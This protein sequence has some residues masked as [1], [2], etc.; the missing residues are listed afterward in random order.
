MKNFYTWDFGNK[1]ELADKLKQL[2][3][4]GRKKATTGLYNKYDKI[5]KVGE[6]AAILDSDRKIP[7]SSK[8]W[9]CERFCSS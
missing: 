4:S 2:V 6:R 9:K 7:V 3:L 5:P 8:S 1:K